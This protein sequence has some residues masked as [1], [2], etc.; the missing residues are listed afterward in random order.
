VGRLTV[1]AVRAWVAAHR[2]LIVA[3]VGAG[4]TLAIQYWGTENLWVSFGILAASSLGVYQV[5]NTPQ[6]GPSA[7]H[8]AH[9]ATNGAR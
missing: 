9:R 8:P 3:L 1:G 2:K 6:P 5:P 7:A 4:L